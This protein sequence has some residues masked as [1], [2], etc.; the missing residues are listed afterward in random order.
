MKIAVL[1]PADIAFRRFMPALKNVPGLEYVGVGVSSPEERV[2]KADE[3]EE[4]KKNTY[5]KSLERAER[6]TAEYG[7]CI[8]D[9]YEKLICSDEISAVYI[10]LPPALHFKWAKLAL[11]HGKHVLLE[12]PATLSTEETKALAELAIAKGLALHENYMFL[13][14]KQLEEINELISSGEIGDV[15]LIQIAFGF[16]MRAQNDFRYDPQMGGGALLDA[17]GYT[18]RYATELLGDTAK[19]KA[20]SLC[21][22]DGFEVDM[23]GAGSMVNA[24]GL[25]A[26]LSFGMDNNYKCNL[27]VWGSKGCLT[28]GRILTAPAGFVPEVVIRKGNTDEVRSLSADDAFANSIKHFVKCIEDENTRIETCKRIV[29]QAE[30]VDEFRSLV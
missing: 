6:F 24:E 16:P 30:L 4:D 5:A 21:Y 3:T 20:A 9:S 23:F 7:G 18:I 26:Q 22:M 15:R 17:G 28:T 14:H 19:L 12:K 8:F 11:E 10:P 27:E 1:C 2:W 29:R 25:T 13:Y